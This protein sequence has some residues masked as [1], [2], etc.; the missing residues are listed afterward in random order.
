MIAKVKSESGK[1]YDTVVFALL[2]DGWDSK[3]IGFDEE[4]RTLRELPYYYLS[5]ERHIHQLFA[6]IDSDETGWAEKESVSGVEWLVS[7]PE[8]LEQI[9]K[10]EPLPEEILT[11]CKAL[12]NEMDLPE[13]RE[14]VPG[15]AREDLLLA[16][17]NFH[18]GVIAAVEWMGDSACISIEVWGAVIHLRLEHA[19]LSE[20]CVVDYG[21]MGEI[22]DSSVF[23]ENGRVYWADDCDFE[24][25]DELTDEF[26]YFSGTRM[27]WKI[28]LN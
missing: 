17:G 4:L 26:C 3:M 21:N 24:H 13:W 9:H 1:V 6:F 16:S 15:K 22:L 18:D 8:L 27:F 20:N 25:F 7:R 10:G 11:R 12:Q 19:E 2:L 23:F 28:E 14:V 5:P